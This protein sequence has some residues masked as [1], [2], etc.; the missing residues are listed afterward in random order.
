MSF[1]KLQVAPLDTSGPRYMPALDGLRAFS[2]ILVMLFHCSVRGFEGGKRGV[3][4]FFVL[5]G[6]LITTLLLEE[7]R[8]T[9]RIKLLYFYIRRA[10]RLYPA[11]LLFLALYALFGWTHGLHVLRAVTCGA[12]YLSDYAIAFDYLRPAAPGDALVEHLWSLAVEEHFYIIWP[13]LLLCLRRAFPGV[14]IVTVIMGLFL[15]ATAWTFV[16]ADLLE[17]PYREVYHRF[18]THAGGLMLG[19][20]L[21]ALRFHGLQLPGLR[22]LLVLSSLGF[23]CCIYSEPSFNAGYYQTLIVD[24]FAFFAIFWLVEDRTSPVARFLSSQPMVVLGRLSYGMYL[25][26]GPI[27]VVLFNGS[28]TLDAAHPAPVFATTFILSFILAGLSYITVEK[29]GRNFGKRF[30]RQAMPGIETAVKA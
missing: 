8:D 21:A 29:L 23:A 19:A 20:L 7:I 1:W 22:M 12:L 24:I 15:A 6:F 5:S 28:V 25:F 27:A 13:L 11:L 4:I 18:D 16:C 2:V 14:N 26:Q 10:L 30:R 9:G 17:Q 3:D